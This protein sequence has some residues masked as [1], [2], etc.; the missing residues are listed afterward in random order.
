MELILELVGSAMQ[1][2]CKGLGSEAMD[3]MQERVIRLRTQMWFAMVSEL[4]DQ[5]STL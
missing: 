1:K 2:S 4:M 5:L 3:I